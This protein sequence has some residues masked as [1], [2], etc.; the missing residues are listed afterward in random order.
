MVKQPQQIAGN[1]VLRLNW[2]VIFMEYKN[3][4]WKLF[5]VFLKI[6]TFTFG[7]GLAMLPLIRKECVETQK[8]IDDCEI[9]DIFAISQ[10]L[11]GVIAINA[12]VFVGKRVAGYKGAIVAAFAVS[13]PAFISILLL[14][15]LFTFMKGNIYI[16]KAFKAIIAA[17][18]ALILVTAIRLAKSAIKGKTG[19][20]AALLSFLLIVVL[21]V[22]AM[23][24]IIA[25]VLTGTVTYL[26]NRRRK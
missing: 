9:V 26:I 17:S 24:V 19:Y 3:K 18:S 15:S 7:G 16:Q 4:L 21:N 23:W 5:I 25:A 22:N 10:S 13:F 8:W 14:I 12:S 6:G 20:I 11:P 1:I 2:D